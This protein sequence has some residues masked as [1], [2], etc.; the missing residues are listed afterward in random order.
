MECQD[1]LYLK[2]KN[3]EFRMAFATKSA[4]HFKGEGAAVKASESLEPIQ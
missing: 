3:K 1:L 2:N 4:G